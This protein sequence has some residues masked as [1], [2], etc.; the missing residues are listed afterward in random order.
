[1]LFDFFHSNTVVDNICSYSDFAFVV[2]PKQPSQIKET[3][4]LKG[5][6]SKTSLS[7]EGTS[8]NKK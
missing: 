7:I 2:T 6:N 8:D 1:M 5:T 4:F 3:R